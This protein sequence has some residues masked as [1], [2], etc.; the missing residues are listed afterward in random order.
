MGRCELGFG[1]TVDGDIG[2]KGH[3][4]KQN[5]MLLGVD[6]CCRWFSSAMLANNLEIYTWVT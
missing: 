1:M 6:V 3:V 2:L 4:E 5:Y